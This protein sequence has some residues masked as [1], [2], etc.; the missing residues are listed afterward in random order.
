MGILN[1]ILLDKDMS[2]KDSLEYI[3]KIMKSIKEISLT[4]TTSNFYLYEMVEESLTTTYFSNTV[5]KILQSEDT[6]K[7]LEMINFTTNDLFHACDGFYTNKNQH[8]QCQL[9]EL[10][11]VWQILVLNDAKAI[12]Q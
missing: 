12:K 10:L 1:E 7:D 8:L 3:L 11:A 4:E 9:V 6:S 5:P 2:R